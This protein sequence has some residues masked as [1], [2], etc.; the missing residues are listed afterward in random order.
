MR[1][2]IGK[3]LSIERDDFL[4]ELIALI[5]N[6][7]LPPFILE[8]ILKDMYNDIHLAAVQQ[9]EKD[10]AMYEEL[11]GKKNQDAEKSNS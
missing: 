8:P 3:P 4:R 9:L 7:K 2:S 11:K 10:R 5:N 6:S 1:D